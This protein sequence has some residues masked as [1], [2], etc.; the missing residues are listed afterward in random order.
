VTARRVKVELN[1]EPL[2]AVVEGRDRLVD[3]VREAGLTGTHVGCDTG[4]CGACTVVLN[5][6]TVRSCLVLAGQCDGHTV[7]TIEALGTPDDLHPVMEA[8][9][10]HHGVQ[11]GFCTPGMVL[12]AVELLDDEPDPD[13]AAV[14]SGLAG[15]VCRCT[16][17]AGIV[18]AVLAVAADRRSA[19]GGPAVAG[20]AG[21]AGAGPGGVAEAG[22]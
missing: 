13:E 21:A 5:G 9:R 15:N 17:Y 19:G 11:C 12:T 3:L 10:R 22:G 18:T 16:G 4:A 14:R 7:T 20:A 1:G 8:F 2:E 6:R